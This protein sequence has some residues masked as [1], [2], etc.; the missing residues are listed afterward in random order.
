MSDRASITFDKA[1]IRA[2]FDYQ[3]FLYDAA[4]PAAD[5]VF[6]IAAESS[7]YELIDSFFNK[8]RDAAK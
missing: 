1:E 3:D 2:F 5:D 8:L 6:E 4:G 7:G